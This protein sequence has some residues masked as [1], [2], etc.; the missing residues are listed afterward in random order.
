MQIA[1]LG[2]GMMGSRMAANLA[3]AG[4]H[5]TVW[6]RTTSRAKEFVAEH[7]GTR[8]ALTPREAADDA[9]IVFSMVVDGRQVHE[10]LLG[11]DGAVDGARPSTLFV[12]CSTIGP[13]YA[14]S[15]GIGL[16]DHGFAFLDAP[17]TGSS[18]R[19][20]AGTLVFMVGGERAEFERVRP[21][22]EAMATL[23]VYA[24]AS[25]QG[26]IVKVINNAVSAVNAVVLGEAL[27]TAQ[28]QGADL[29][30]LVEVMGAGSGGSM[31]LELKAGPMRMHDYA[32]LFR[33]DHMLKDVRL[34]LEAGDAAGIDFSYA[35]DT[36]EVLGRASAMGYGDADFA[37]LIEVLE[38]DADVRLGE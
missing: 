19:A 11:R 14:R 24:G 22:L 35:R 20:A 27:L 1:F 38:V 9:D 37:A 36:D 6:N 13:E 32:P 15:I 25:G 21:V 10:L 16:H 26:Q 5:L 33:L 28:R 18:P 34:C 8:L 3:A 12:D 30:A 7:P 23:I 29:D 17:V 2:L 31:M 4:Y